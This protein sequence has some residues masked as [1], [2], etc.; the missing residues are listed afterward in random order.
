MEKEREK[1]ASTNDNVDSRKDSAQD[2]KKDKDD[3]VVEPITCYTSIRDES[4]SDS[5][6]D[7]A[8]SDKSKTANSPSATTTTTRKPTTTPTTTATVQKFDSDSE[9]DEKAEQAKS[10]KNVLS[11]LTTTIKNSSSPSKKTPIIKAGQTAKDREDLQVSGSGPGKM[12]FIGP[13]LPMLKTNNSLQQQQSLTSVNSSDESKTATAVGSSSGNPNDD[14]SSSGGCLNDES[15]ATGSNPQK[16]LNYSKDELAKYD[17]LLR[18]SQF[19]AKYNQV[20]F[21]FS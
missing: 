9:T 6:S 2:E 1:S 16:E 8:D 18:M 5:G 19:Y 15:A 7:D 21:L 12:S 14:V 17:H 20:Y 3:A 11:K 10:Y 13:K 4:D